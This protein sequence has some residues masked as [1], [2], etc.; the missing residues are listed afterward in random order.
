M[1]KKRIPEEAPKKKRRALSVLEAV[2]TLSNLAELDVEKKGDTPWLDDAKVRDN[3]EKIKD[4]FETLNSYLQH[5]YQKE[6]SELNNP[7]T[8]RGIQAM[9]RLAGEAV[10]KVGKFTHIFQENIEQEKTLPEYQQLQHFYLSKIVKKVEGQKGDEAWE[11]EI[12]SLEEAEIDVERQALKDLEAVRS[13]K[14]YEL[15]YIYK[16]D[17]MPFFNPNLLRHVRLVGNFDESLSPAES[18]NPLSRLD[19]VL[20]RDLHAGCK[21]LLKGSEAFLQ[22]YFKE[23]MKYKESVFTA[24]LNKSIMALM[25]GANPRNLIGNESGKCAREYFADFQKYLRIALAS[26]EYRKYLNLPIEKQDPHLRTALRLCHAFCGLLFLRLGPHHDV[27]GFIK[28]ITEKKE[29]MLPSFW[30]TLAALDENIREEFRNLPSGPLLKTLTA[31]REGEEREGFDPLLQGNPPSQIFSLSSE[32]MHMTFLHLPSP[33]RQDYIDRVEVVPEFD[34]YLRF[35][36]GKKHL[37]VNLQD[38]T[39]WKEHS[40]SQKLEEISKTASRE[41][42]LFV[43]SLTKSTD[44]YYQTNEAATLDNAQQ[45]CQQL[46]AQIEGGE[47]CGYFIPPQIGAQKDIPKMI[48][49]VHE[50]FFE[51]KPKLARKE[52]LDFIEIFYFFFLLLILDKHQ[53]DSVSFTCKDAVDTGAAAS[54]SFFGFARMLSAGT[55][56]HEEDRNF[57][58]YTFYA[59][60]LLVRHRPIDSLRFHRAVSALDH[61]EKTLSGKREKILKACADLFPEI[62]IQ[63]LKVNE[64]A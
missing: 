63:K 6:R 15:F 2:D 27:L 24:T 23:A 4:T 50:H 26:E 57:F 7:Q 25:L 39:S 35:L 32:S 29:K 30:G 40:R 3:Q 58:L 38:R 61:F 44:F 31:F 18:D 28:Q 54:A 56:W 33:T 55:A 43:L 1:A 42:S 10:D 37:L 53:P 9:M 47:Q 14:E 5:L 46:Q 13:D 11:K 8:Q 22:D 34:G 51:K 59:P 21:D 20:D 60:A 19:V 48:A 12:K 62:P 52:R 17:G 41:E 49:F 45:F 16:E 64:A 36:A